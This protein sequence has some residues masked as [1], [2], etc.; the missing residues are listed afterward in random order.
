[1]MTSL[2][3]AY[4]P[5]QHP[6]GMQQHPGGPQGHPMGIPQNP[7]QGPQGMPQQMH[8]GVS[9][10]GGQQVSQ[11]G[12]M[13][14]GI[15]PGAG[16]P[17]AHALQHLN[18][19]AAQQQQLLQQQQ[20]LAFANNPQF[21]MQQQQQQQQHIMAQQRQAQVARQAM[22]A[23]QY[24][25]MPMGM[26]PNA[27]GQMTQAQFQAMR[28][29]NPMGVARPVNL[30]QHLQQQQQQAQHSLE[31]Q[32][33]QAHAQAQHQHQQQLIAAQQAAM[34]QQQQ[35]NAQAQPGN[36]MGQQLNTQQMQSMQ[37]QHL[38]AQAAQQAH[39]QQAAAAAAA[40]QNQ[41][42][43]AQAQ[44]SQQQPSQPNQQAQPQ[45]AQQQAQPQQPGMAQPT[46]AAVL[47]QQ[48][49]TGE[50]FRGQCLLRLSLF[51]DHLS[52]FGGSKHKDDLS[53]WLSFVDRFFSSKGVL[54]HSVWMMDE[55]SNKQ[56]EITFPG[57]ARYFHTHFESGIKTMQ[58]I[59]QRGSEK[60]L[61]N[62]GH[63]I[64]SPKA[65]FVYW[66]DNGSQLI[67]NGTLRAHFDSDQ[68]IELLE[69]VTNNHEEYL[70]RTKIIEAARPM[71][72]WGK[73]WHKVNAAPDGKQSPEMNKK[74]AKKMNSPN[75]APPDI[76]LPTSKVKP[77]M[78]VTP[79]VFRF[80]EI[81]EVLEQMSPLFGYSHQHSSLAPYGALE[82]YVTT[83]AIGANNANGPQN[84]AGP[85]TPGLNNFPMGASP[86]L[87]NP[88]LPGSPHIGGS[89]ALGANMSISASQ[90]G[91]S[92][93]GPSANTSPNASNKRRRPSAVKA[94]EEGQMNGAKKGVNPSPRITK[95][96]KPNA[97]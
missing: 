26:N 94:E 82:Q 5:S 69:F 33:H 42:A 23:Q 54:R 40:Q 93:S 46:P 65:S 39:Q 24:S 78:G 87:T 48:R 30:P 45:Q 89:P 8:M 77:N 6:G 32:Q 72:E 50:K 62:N 16:G 81:A 52:N 38:A 2:H 75:Q 86:A 74:K 22:M 21:Q 43:Q 28:G 53:Y 60:D 4:P 70:P 56:Y 37:Q 25:G 3:N 84:P 31:Q 18:P 20:Q 79:S 9:G 10:P 64:E 85:R 41:P 76:E 55:N 36:N 90:H 66:F 58:L 63:Y 68:K 57:I 80:F 73:E 14:G 44:Q 92:S 12:A 71:H 34:Q 17:S 88:G 83:V 96:Q 13:M 11:A 35:A 19:N 47:M 91:T 61:P 67:A 49:Q 97:A 29:Q 51:A 15:P 59:V 27:M 95:R 1:M 7:G